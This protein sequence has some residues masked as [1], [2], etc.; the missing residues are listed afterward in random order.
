VTFDDLNFVTHPNHGVGIRA[1]AFFP[2]G[3][4]VSV[5]RSP[6]SY[7][8]PA[9]LYEAAVL[10]GDADNCALTYDTPV[11]DDVEGHLT[12]EGVTAFVQK[13]R[14]LPPRTVSA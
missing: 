1:T 7:G 10:A 9:G 6:Y 8:G 11:T 12:P 5:I 13:V 4:G 2:N 3:Y 14:A